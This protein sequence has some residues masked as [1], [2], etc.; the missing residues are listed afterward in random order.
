LAPAHY[1]GT[2]CL[3]GTAIGVFL[4]VQGSTYKFERRSIV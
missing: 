1:V 3:L 2:L 4:I